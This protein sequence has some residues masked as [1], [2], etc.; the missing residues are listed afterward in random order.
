MLA[1]V[2]EEFGVNLLNPFIRSRHQIFVFYNSLLD[3]EKFFKVCTSF[4]S[5]V[6]SFLERARQL[7]H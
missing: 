6:L 5:S 2:S 7:F 4:I 3:F 1:P